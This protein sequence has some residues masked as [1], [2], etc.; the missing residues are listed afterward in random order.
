MSS[1][2]S[3]YDGALISELG[4]KRY[5][6]GVRAA[7]SS[8]ID[9]FIRGEVANKA[10]R[11]CN[12]GCHGPTYRNL[13]R[14]ANYAETLRSINDLS[15]I[16]AGVVD[17]LHHQTIGRAE[18][19]ANGLERTSEGLRLSGQEAF[20]QVGDENWAIYEFASTT[21]E[22]LVSFELD[23][24]ENPLIQLITLIVTEYV[25]VL[26]EWV[27]REAFEQ[28][29]L[30]LSEPIDTVWLLKA[31][32]LGLI[33]NTDKQDLEHAAKL[34][35]DPA[36][37]LVGRTI[38]KK[39]ASAM[40]A[41]LASAITRKLIASSA[42]LPTIRQNLKSLK[43]EAAKLK[44]G[45]GGT[46]IAL[47]AAQGILQKAGESSR[48][49]YTA[50][51]RLWGI[52]RYQLNGTNMVYFLVEDML[53]EYVDRLSLLEKQPSEFAKVMQALIKDRKTTDI[54]FPGSSW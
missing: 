12:F 27:V 21:F 33:K 22:R 7:P 15:P 25:S 48:R 16:L 39:L 43:S 53:K 13:R 14:P 34:L 9:F 51:P 45:L 44:G 49:L 38:G 8:N 4:V 36:Q 20:Q 10:W 47:L 11:D 17:G 46:L 18:R 40:A 2:D 42:N 37:R 28:G 32:T 31:A 35:N 52:L 5:L 54:F 41:A 26:P 6:K 1:T 19:L 29:A 50:S 30:K 3:T 24:L 23:T